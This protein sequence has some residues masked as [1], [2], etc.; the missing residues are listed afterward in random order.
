LATRHSGA[1]DA[2]GLSCRNEFALVN[3]GS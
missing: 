2:A 3:I 1:Q